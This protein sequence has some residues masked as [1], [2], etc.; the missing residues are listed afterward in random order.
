[1][2]SATTTESQEFPPL[3]EFL[4]F[5]EAFASVD[6]QDSPGSM[7]FLDLADSP[8]LPAQ[9][10]LPELLQDTDLPGLPELLSNLIE[11]VTDPALLQVPGPSLAD[12]KSI[13]CFSYG[14]YSAIKYADNEKVFPS[15]A[16]YSVS[17]AYLKHLDG[18]RHENSLSDHRFK[19]KGATWRFNARQNFVCENDELFHTHPEVRRVVPLEK[20]HQA[21]TWAHCKTKHQ[22]RDKTYNYL[23]DNY[24]PDKITKAFVIEWLRCC[25]SCKQMRALEKGRDAASREAHKTMAAAIAE[26]AIAAPALAFDGVVAIPGLGPQDDDVPFLAPFPVNGL[27]PAV[28][29]IF[30]STPIAELD[31]VPALS[32][33]LVDDAVWAPMTPTQT[34][35]AVR[36][37]RGQQAVKGNRREG[38]VGEDRALRRTAAG[39]RIDKAPRKN[40]ALTVPIAANPFADRQPPAAMDAVALLPAVDTFGDWTPPADWESSPPTADLFADLDWEA[41]SAWPTDPQVESPWCGFILKMLLISQL[42]VDV[43]VT[44]EEGGI[45]E[46]TGGFDM[47]MEEGGSSLLEDEDFW[48]A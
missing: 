5:Q 9:P 27:P 35:H 6:S 45:F 37:R 20:L 25:P 41:L 11:N 7:D 21:L 48:L 32:P 17:R 47:A 42:Q 46:D 39:S 22:G 14:K 26:A 12:T 10:K 33:D 24:W 36:R 1:M 31:S 16:Y 8:V 19:A 40:P 28:A 44:A 15:A 38:Q 34:P 43:A 29:P 4:N 13:F 3:A 30:P 2:S 18:G 23:K